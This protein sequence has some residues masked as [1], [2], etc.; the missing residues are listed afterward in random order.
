MT[1]RII[2][3]PTASQSFYYT[4]TNVKEVTK[5]NIV[6][7]DGS[8]TP[9]RICSK[10]EIISLMDAPDDYDESEQFFIDL[11]CSKYDKIR[12]CVVSDRSGYK[13]MRLSQFNE[14]DLP[15]FL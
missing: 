14:L 2:N 3:A 12:E 11:G 4:A 10:V 1:I 7:H 6:F 8:T 5:F 9:K 15:N 13:K